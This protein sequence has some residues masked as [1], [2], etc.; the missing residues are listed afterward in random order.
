[1][2]EGVQILLFDGALGDFGGHRVEHFA[3]KPLSAQKALDD[4]PGRLALA[5]SR[6]HGA[7]SELSIAPVEIGIEV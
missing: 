5:E 3:E 2:A 1:M 4:P 7:G 6:N